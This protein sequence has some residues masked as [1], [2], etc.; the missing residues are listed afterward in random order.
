MKFT[1]KNKVQ[2]KNYL[3][4]NYR[5]ELITNPYN[6]FNIINNSDLIVPQNNF[7]QTTKTFKIPSRHNSN[8]FLPS[9]INPIYSPK[10]KP[11]NSIFFEE[12]SDEAYNQYN[13][14]PIIKKNLTF[15]KTNQNSVQINNVIFNQIRLTKNDKII[16]NS[17]QE[18]PLDNYNKKQLNPGDIRR[19]EAKIGPPPIPINSVDKTK[20]SICKISYYFN[21]TTTFGTG[22]FFEI[23]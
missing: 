10:R 15:I 4:P 17:N 12:V 8:N 19:N 3:I 6:T 21:N 23:F 1:K 18:Y 22:F 2:D 14:P 13:Q 5:T 11:K 16:R 20:K 9:Q 7:S